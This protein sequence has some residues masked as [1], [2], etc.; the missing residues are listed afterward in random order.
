MYTIYRFHGVWYPLS[1]RVTMASF[2]YTY[3][4]TFEGLSIVTAYAP[5]SETEAADRNTFYGAIEQRFPK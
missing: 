3:M 4:Y 2:R 1:E 5:T